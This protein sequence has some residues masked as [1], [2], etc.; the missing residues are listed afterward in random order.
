MK[1]I[2]CKF[3]IRCPKLATFCW[4]IPF[5]KRSLLSRWF[6]E[7]PPFFWDIS[8]L[9]VFFRSRLP[10]KVKRIQHTFCRKLILESAKG[11]VLKRFRNA[12]HT[13]AKWP[14]WAPLA[15]LQVWKKTS[16]L[17][18]LWR[19]VFWLKRW[20]I[21]FCW[22]WFH[23]FKLFGGNFHVLFGEDFYFEHISSGSTDLT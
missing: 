1:W 20:A 3:S 16:K 21:F 10:K 22:W 6:S 11:M 17:V 14:V 19:F 4:H 5:P 12:P 18:H 23:G 9:R 15:Q 8:L 7:L 2:T 13:K